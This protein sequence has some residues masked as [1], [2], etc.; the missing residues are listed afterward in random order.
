M[1]NLQEEKRMKLVKRFFIVMSFVV[2]I[3]FTDISVSAQNDVEIYNIIEDIPESLDTFKTIAEGSI[4]AIEVDGQWYYKFRREKYP[5]VLIKVSAFTTQPQNNYLAKDISSLNKSLAEDSDHTYNRICYYTA[6][7]KEDYGKYST[8]TTSINRIDLIVSGVDSEF[9]T[10]CDLTHCVSFR[11]DTKVRNVA[12]IDDKN[13]F[14][15]LGIEE[16]FIAPSTAFEYQD[17]LSRYSDSETM[18]PE[19]SVEVENTGE[20]NIYLAKYTIAGKGNAA[21][22]GKE[23]V[24]LLFSTIQLGKDIVLTDYAGMVGDVLNFDMGKLGTISKDYNSGLESYLSKNKKF[25]YK[26]IYK[27][28]IKLSKKGDCVQIKTQCNKMIEDA[29]FHVSF[30]FNN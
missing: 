27:S 12:R 11:Y 5:D 6:M 21:S 23:L 30:S 10:R 16:S 4:S 24:N 2:C 22:D 29:I 18:I 17:A 19:I 9:S 15:N 8:Y 25:V 26:T 28:P 14:D 7:E 1:G 13:S 3:L 20:N